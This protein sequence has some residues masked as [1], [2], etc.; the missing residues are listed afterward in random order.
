MSKRCVK[1]GIRLCEACSRVV[2]NR[3]LYDKVEV[4]C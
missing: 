1:T 4:Q 3:L 2:R